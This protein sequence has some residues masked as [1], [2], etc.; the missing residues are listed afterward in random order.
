MCVYLCPHIF[1]HLGL[2]LDGL[3]RDVGGSNLLGDASS[4]TVLDVGVSQLHKQ[5]QQNCQN[6]KK[7]VFI[8]IQVFGVIV[9][10]HILYECAALHLYRGISSSAARVMPIN[11]DHSPMAVCPSDAH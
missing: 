6:N 4:F 5:I 10:A 1:D 11:N 9:S 2:L 7:N 3:P 8:K